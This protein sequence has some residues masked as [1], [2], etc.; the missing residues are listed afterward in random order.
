MINTESRQIVIRFR[1]K[2]RTSFYQYGTNFPIF[3]FP[4]TTSKRSG[5]VGRSRTL[6]LISCLVSLYDEIRYKYAAGDKCGVTRL[7]DNT[8]GNGETKTRH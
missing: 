2:G 3:I 1:W 8:A 4:K 5:S 7:L 6:F